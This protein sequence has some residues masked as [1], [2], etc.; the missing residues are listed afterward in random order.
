VNS[1]LL[2]LSHTTT[3]IRARHTT[4]PDAFLMLYS[5]ATA[6]QSHCDFKP[7]RTVC[8]HGVAAGRQRLRLRTHPLHDRRLFSNEQA[9]DRSQSNR[10]IHCSIQSFIHSIPGPNPTIRPRQV[11]PGTIA[12]HA[13]ASLT[14]HPQCEKGTR[15]FG[16]FILFIP[17][18]IPK[19]IQVHHST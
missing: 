3:L 10:S 13:T 8:R 11:K 18:F 15:D 12:S 5:H 4:S 17:S 6:Y 14:R 7:L 9:M 19:I 16:G 2:R 1:Q